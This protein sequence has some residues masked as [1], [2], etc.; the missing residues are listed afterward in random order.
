MSRLS[1]RFRRANERDRLFI[2]N[3]NLHFLDKVLLPLFAVFLCLNFLDV[4]ST[5]L[6]LKSATA[7]DFRELNPIASVLFSMHF[8]GFLIALTFKYLPAIPLFYAVFVRDSQNK[9]PYEIRLVRFVALVALAAA[10]MYL[11][12]IV[13]VN[14]IP[15]LMA[16][17][18][19]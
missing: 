18:G 15:T 1:E 13:A 19:H 7:A 3:L 4:Y 5:I 12:Y 6:A 11:G 2:M 10:D 17:L 14:N 9:H 16:F 8:N